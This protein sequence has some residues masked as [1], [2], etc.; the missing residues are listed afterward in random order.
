MHCRLTTFLAFTALTSAHFVLDWPPT[1]GFDDDNESNS[2]CG[3]ATVS[4]NSSSPQVNVDR[5]AASITVTH[6]SGNFAFYATTDT[7]EPYTFTKISQNVTSGA[8]GNFCENYLSVPESFAGKAGVLQ[9]I[10]TS[11][12]GVLYQ[13]GEFA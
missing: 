10:D 7:Q 13:V 12:D 9:V 4:V 2:P 3:G 1:A 11:I 5:F 8:I 6:P